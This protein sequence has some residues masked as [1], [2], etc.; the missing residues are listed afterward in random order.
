LRH[1]SP[2]NPAKPDTKQLARR[3]KG[4]TMKELL[5]LTLGFAALAANG[6]QAQN[7]SRNCAPRDAVLERLA[8]SYG[9]TRQS[10][11]LGT[12]NAVV[13]TFAS[14]ETGSWTIVVTQPSGIS[15]LVASGQAFEPV[16]EELKS[17]Y[18]KDA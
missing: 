6:A 15:C 1:V 10:I 13:E 11:G 18:D 4:M 7:Q 2:E 16:T 5:F 12:N 17:A 9:E 8:S 3:Q 14:L